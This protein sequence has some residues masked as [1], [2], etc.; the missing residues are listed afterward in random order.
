LLD[1]QEQLAV[2]SGLRNGNRQSWAR[3]YDAYSV[4]VWRYVTRLLGSDGPAVADAVQETFMEAARSARHFD[5]SRGTLWTWLTGIAHHRVAAYWR[6]AERAARLRKLVESRAEEIRHWLDAAEPSDE[7]R[8]QQEMAELVRCT[9]AELPA[10][11]AA[12]LTAKYLDELTLQELSEHG[13]ASIDA[14]KSKL[15]RARR[16]FRA[17][18]ERLAREPTRL[19]RE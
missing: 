6:Q 12:I 10:D 16:E 8:Q 7:P 19:T 14:I 18:F 1:H 13:D 3:L 15:A 9:L 2:A 5:A 4:D 17:R 11:Y